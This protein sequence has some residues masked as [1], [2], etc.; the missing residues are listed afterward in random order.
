MTLRC[1]VMTMMNSLTPELRPGIDTL[2]LGTSRSGLSDFVRAKKLR[3]KK[4]GR[5]RAARSYR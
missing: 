1:L 4:C 2:A 5:R 3:A